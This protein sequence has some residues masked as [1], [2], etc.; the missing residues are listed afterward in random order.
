M[1]GGPFYCN[2]VGRFVAMDGAV[3]VAVTKLD[4][5]H[6]E[7]ACNSELRAAPTTSDALTSWTD[8]SCY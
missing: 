8:V 3:M 4:I 1:R 7:V 6:G 2:V 5:A